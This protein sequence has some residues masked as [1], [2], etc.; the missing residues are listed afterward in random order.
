MLNAKEKR[1]YKRQDFRE[2]VEY[3]VLENNHIGACLADNLCFGG[4][5]INFDS[6]VPTDTKLSLRFKLPS[7]GYIDRN[8]E[9]VWVKECPYPNR[10]QLGIKLNNSLSK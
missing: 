3:R 5:L 6:F 1:F 7:N 4:I 10:Y 2:S 8:G 9:V